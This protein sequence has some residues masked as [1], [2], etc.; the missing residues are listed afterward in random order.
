MK[1]QV[2]WVSLWGKSSAGQYTPRHILGFRFRKDV[3]RDP[4]EGHLPVTL[5][6]DSH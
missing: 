1:V 6:L 2:A 5:P 4:H 3:L